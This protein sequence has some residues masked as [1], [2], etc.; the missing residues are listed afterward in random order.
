MAFGSI[1]Q[2]IND[3][4]QRAP[5]TGEVA[6]YQARQAN[7]GLSDADLVREL[8][9]GV[10]GNT[11]A[12][13][14]V[15]PVLRFYQGVYGRVPD[16][17]GLN[18]WV[19]VYR[20]NL[21]LDNPK[22][23]TQNEALVALARP[24]VDPVQTPEFLSRYGSPPA[25]YS[26]PAWQAYATGFIDK[27][28]LNVL[29]RPADAQ[30]LVYW[31]NQFLAKFNELRPVF[32][33]Q[34]KTEAQAAL[35]A[36]AI[37]LEQFTNSQEMKDS[38]REWIG[39]F[40]TGAAH[41][42]DPTGH[43]TGSLFNDAPLGQ[44][45]VFNAVEDTTLSVGAAAGV[46]ANDRDTDF[47]QGLTVEL[48][49]PPP[50]GNLTLLPDGSFT[51]VPAANANGAVQFTY[52]TF[53]GT[54]YSA[55]VTVTINVAAVN[56]LPVLTAP[57]SLSVA[58]A[59]SSTSLAAADVS[60]A[61][62]S[63]QTYSLTAVLS[64]P[65]RGSL[66]GSGGTYNA[67][68]GTYSITNQTLAGINAALDALH[69]NATQAA[70]NSVT[71][72]FT[73]SAGGS[74]GAHSISLNYA[75]TY[76]IAAGT[77]LTAPEGG[78]KREVTFTI[79]R[80]DP[81]VTG[82]VQWR[83]DGTGGTT[84]SDFGFLIQ[85]NGFLQQISLGLDYS[86]FFSVGETT[87]TITF[88]VA[89][90]AL[91]EPDDAFTISLVNPSDGA[92][93]QNGVLEGMIFNDDVG[94]NAIER[95]TVT[96]QGQQTSGNVTGA[97]MS[98]D[99]RYVVFASGANNIVNGDLNAREDIFLRDRELGTTVLASVTPAGGFPDDHSQFPAIAADG[100]YLAYRHVSGTLVAGDTSDAD[101]ILTQRSTLTHSIA[102]LSFTGGDA[103]LGPAGFSALSADGRFV[104][105][106]SRATNHIANDSNGRTDVFVFDR[107]S[108]T[109]TRASQGPAGQQGN[110]DS[111]R[112]DISAD[113]SMVVF[114]TSATNFAPNDTNLLND[115][116]L[117]NMLDGSLT[118]IS[119]NTAGEQAS[120]GA[121]SPTI[122]SD[123]QRI[124]FNSVSANL[125]ANDTNG[126]T[127]VFVRDVQ[128]GTT[129][130]VSVSSSGASG[131]STSQDPYIS[132][133]GRYVAFT[134]FAS[135]LVQGDG[136]ATSD[137]FVHDLETSKTYLVSMAPNGGSGNQFST[138]LD[139][140]DDGRYV[141]ISSFASDLIANDTNG[142]TDVFVVD[143]LN[144][145]WFG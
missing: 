15:F 107:I 83:V 116:F 6:G 39:S 23:P 21:G 8:V 122:S 46:L 64:V 138:A 75:N 91:V 105:F 69:Y 17:G 92:I 74:S 49:T 19:N 86:V 63:G 71:L 50:V 2:M 12:L 38:T 9:F 53:D 25:Q 79:S 67:L 42:P 88:E 66:V 103:N 72:T 137:A 78:A 60:D 130:M 99:G 54:T 34:K 110:G 68:T 115:I 93:I 87:K 4:L 13:D 132:G 112:V 20:A 141:L 104:A 85:G 5:R 10:T 51:Y 95:I 57:S 45:D 48:V 96:S 131:N 18:Y 32:L 77:G 28:Y 30:G 126:V 98:G 89:G 94:V 35:E 56:D 1:T 47:G 127:D 100:S 90:D 97:A 24:F 7:S 125:V 111:V 65:S 22:T 81:T 140:S 80:S 3:I 133:N 134:S 145:W 82:A 128:D 135:N 16:K 26:G 139:I 120:L 52:R 121:S 40:L 11:E 106:T 143:G 118:L 61:D 31:T 113:G 129:R 29:Q 124:A 142:A 117:K 76:S 44:A 123:G 55:P 14:V 62:G 108:Q 73:D 102:S 144:L 37:Y 41:D 84:A 27:L 109:T 58:G 36:R 136:N 33:A 101:I 59:G 43:Y 119:V 114:E 70:S